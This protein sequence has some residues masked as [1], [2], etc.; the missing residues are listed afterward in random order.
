MSASHPDDDAPLGMFARIAGRLNPER[1]LMGLPP[2][3]YAPGT[4]PK[5]DD[6]ADNRTRYIARESRALEGEIIAPVRGSR[7]APHK[8][9][10]VVDPLSLYGQVIPAKQ[11]IVEDWLPVGY[12][13]LCYGKDGSNKTLLSQQLMTACATGMPWLGMQVTECR[14]YGFFCEDGEDDIALRQS[15]INARLGIG[16]QDVGNMRWTCPVGDDNRLIKFERG[17]PMLTDRFHWL[18]EEI[19]SFE[20]KLAVIDTAGTVF[21]GNEI[22]RG[23]VT[24]FVGQ[25]LTSLARD[26]NGA[27]LLNAH[28]SRT[29]RLTGSGDSGST[30]WSASAR[31]RWYVTKPAEEGIGGEEDPNVRMLTRVKSNAASAGVSIRMVWRDWFLE[32]PGTTNDAASPFDGVNRMLA[33]EQ[34]FLTLLDRCDVANVPVSIS[35]QS[36]SYAPKVFFRR[37]DAGGFSLREFERALNSLISREAIWNAPYVGSDRHTRFRLA[38]RPENDAAGGAGGGL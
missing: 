9:P 20:A 30:A 4:R 16:F 7:A 14:S 32:V 26:M 35:R 27:V 28:P 15:A 36:S 18:R 21:G 1:Q 10:P 37:D 13:T 33:A 12:A 34:H 25:V 3:L 2:A 8:P 17:D 24:A 5:D 23:Q 31:S 29:G 22:D 6:D 11:W 19:L 38:R